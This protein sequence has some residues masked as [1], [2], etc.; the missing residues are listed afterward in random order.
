MDINN[1]IVSKIKTLFKNNIK[2][3]IGIIIGVIISSFTVYGATIIF[4]SDAVGFDNTNANLTLNNTSVDNVQDA[5]DAL[6]TKVQ[7]YVPPKCTNS[8]FKLGDYI[9]M[10]PTSTSFTP[11]VD[12]TGC[13]EASTSI[14]GDLNPSELSVW[15]VLRINGDC[16]VELV[17]EYV[18]SVNV[19][20]GG[21]TGYKNYIWYLNQI[22]KQYANTAYTLNPSTAPDGAFRN[23]GYDP[24]QQTAQIIDE[25]YITDSTLGSASDKPGYGNKVFAESKGGGDTGFGIDMNLLNEANINIRA[26]KANSTTFINYWLASR[27]FVWDNASAWTFCARYVNYD[28]NISASY[29]WGWYSSSVHAYGNSNAVRPVVTLKSNITHSSGSGTSDSHYQLSVS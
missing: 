14:V 20:F 1:K 26:Y 11:D 10:T 7:A 29:L 6:Y 24:E 27:L 21:K 18:S 22:A 25:S 4:D 28:G 2:L 17:S 9:D 3:I 23:I 13:T 12:L 15:R 8:L 19:K 5:I 16:T